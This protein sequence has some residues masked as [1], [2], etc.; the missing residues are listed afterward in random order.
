M[1]KSV[2]QNLE[3]F[4]PIDTAIFFNSTSKLVKKMNFINKMM[5]LVKTDDNIDKV[6]TAIWKIFS[7]YS[8][9][10]TVLYAKEQTNNRK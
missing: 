3:L 10:I 8:S 4:Q 1:T 2:C 6:Y 9:S 5:G 7:Y